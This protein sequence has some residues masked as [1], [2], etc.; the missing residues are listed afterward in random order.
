MPLET[1]IYCIG[2]GI[3]A[4]LV[5]LFQYIY[6]TNRNK[7]YWSLAALRF[8]SIFSLLLLII[9]PKFENNESDV[10]KPVLAIA[11][12]NSQSISYLTKDSIAELT[13][14]TILK[15]SALNTKYDVQLYRF[16]SQI[17]QNS[18]L[19]FEDSQTNITNSLEDIQSIYDSQLAPIVLITDG[20]QTI[21]TD[22]QFVSKQFNQ[23]VFP[24]ILGDSIYNT[25]L[26]IQHVNVNS[27][28][29]L[30]K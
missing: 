15:N 21:G 14:K 22:Y 27:Y 17:D 23:V 18:S 7:L 24:F 30:N 16:G 10:V 8:V 20:N 28:T 5:A 13:T 11:V 29:Y 12:D 25:D 6:K 26:K 2:S 1:L 9:N 19:T 3:L 4:L